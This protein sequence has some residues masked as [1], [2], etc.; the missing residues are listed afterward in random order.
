VPK[1]HLIASKVR[2]KSL[3]VKR[4]KL[5]G[6]YL[7][8]LNAAASKWKPSNGEIK[9]KGEPL[10]KK[11]PF[12]HLHLHTE[13]SFRDSTCNLNGIMTYALAMGQ[14]FV[15]MTDNSALYGA[16]EFD[17]MARSGGR[18]CGLQPVI[19]CEVRMVED[20]GDANLVLL[21][22]TREGYH[23]LMRM[24]S[25]S[26]LD[27]FR[28][29]EKSELRQ[30][31]RGLIGLSAGGDGAIF[32]YCAEGSVQKATELAKEY[33]EIFGP[34][35]FFLEIQDH[36]FRE[37]KEAKPN[38]L[39]VA[40]I[41]RLPL[42]ATNDVHYLAQSD[43]K[44]YGLLRDLFQ[45]GQFS[46][47][48]TE[49]CSDQFYMKSGE[50]MREL[51]PDLPEALANT[52]KIARRCNV[53]LSGKIE[54]GFPESPLPPG[55][56]KKQDYLVS[57]GREGLKKRYS[58]RISG[59]EFKKAS[60]KLNYEL[61]MARK[62]KLVDYFLIVQ[63]IVRWAKARGIPVG[64]GR[65]KEAGSLL[66][67]VLGITE[68]DPIHF[69]LIHKQTA[70]PNRFSQ[71]DFDLEF[72]HDRR[73]EVIEYLRNQYPGRVAQI[74]VLRRF[75]PRAVYRETGRLLGYP[76]ADCE[77]F[78]EMIPDR[79][80]ALRQARQESARF[81]KACES[82]PVA[83]EIMRHASLLDRLPYKADTHAAAFVIS[84]IPLIESVP[85][86]NSNGSI[87]PAV[88][89]EKQN[90]ED[91]GFM[92]LDILSLRVLTHIQRVL[93]LIEI[94]CG[95]K[96]NLFALPQNDAKTFARL[97]AG[98]TEGVFLLEDAKTR[99]ALQQKQPSCMDDLIQVLNVCGH[100][101]HAVSRAVLAYQAAYLKAN[102]PKQ[103]RE[104]GVCHES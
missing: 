104:E 37:Q 51:F 35:N 24:V 82:D 60:E 59:D 34:K 70:R 79:A 81:K 1:R 32:K 102:F 22:E 93:D 77:R 6:F 75:T 76:E 48:Q 47:E 25:L 78:A 66:A 73:G 57:L 63:D 41:A 87:M 38:L 36:G 91:L 49:A 92:T 21:A 40:R 96:P 15:A 100:K 84:G 9:E 58:N 64:P 61:A 85:L 83:R 13:Y 67:Y 56:D 5:G 12:C 80:M 97:C 8:F 65:G 101:G 54:R 55:C 69:G 98:D 74:T 28:S 89:F 46:Y 14:E 86:T 90:I 29:I 39:E 30:Y 18:L 52:V 2:S 68:I 27:G 72:C 71:P 11:I 3:Q 26:H 23:N 42:V 88:Q 43:H 7:F 19:G 4:F 95:P 33:A 31:S 17:R 62:S 103:W 16:L 53:N 44:A 50:E 10:M 20:E 99:A 45:N 94:G